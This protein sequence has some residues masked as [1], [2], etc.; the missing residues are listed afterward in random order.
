MDY[1]LINANLVEV[2]T[3]SSSVYG[4]NVCYFIQ[5][6]EYCFSKS[7]LTLGF[8]LKA[9]A[10]FSFIFGDLI[11][12]E[13]DVILNGV[14]TKKMAV[15]LTSFARAYPYFV[16]FLVLPFITFMYRR[17]SV[18]FTA[19]Y[20]FCATFVAFMLLFRVASLFV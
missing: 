15:P 12:V 9:R 17:S 1:H 14:M 19:S 20:L 18:A 3:S 5:G 16:A 4:D 11:N 6:Q 8:K 13:Q 7:E 10:H 2:N